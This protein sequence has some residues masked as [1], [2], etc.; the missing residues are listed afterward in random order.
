MEHWSPLVQTTLWVL[1]VGGIVWRFNKPIH[2][3]LEALQKRVESGSGVKAGPFELSAPVRPQ[4]PAEQ[5]SK[6]E[7]EVEELIAH[8]PPV[9][10]APAEGA[11]NQ[12]KIE[13]LGVEDL[14]LRA[15]Q[16]AYNVPINRQVVVGRDARFDGAFVKYEALYVVEVKYMPGEPKPSRIRQSLEQASK[17]LIDAGIHKAT[18][19]LAL[20]F[21]SSDHIAGLESMLPQLTAS[22]AFPTDVRMFSKSKLQFD[23]SPGPSDGG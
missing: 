18:I 12:L 1:L 13:Y 17:L 11:L 16:V 2:G 22:S 3:L 5:R 14:A 7:A 4:N 20:V 9:L 8:A 19:I 21:D 10:A 15:V 23:F 6:A